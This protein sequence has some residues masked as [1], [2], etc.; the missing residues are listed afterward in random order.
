[1]NLP[2]VGSD[3]YLIDEPKWMVRVDKIVLKPKFSREPLIYVIQ[4][5][6][7][8]YFGLDFFNYKFKIKKE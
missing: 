4:T 5:N 1:M 6:G 8:N 2:K 3:Y 7:K